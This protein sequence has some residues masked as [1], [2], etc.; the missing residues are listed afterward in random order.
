MQLF[1]VNARSVMSLLSYL[2]VVVSFG[3]LHPSSTNQQPPEDDVMSISITV[4]AHQMN[5]K[6]KL[7]LL[8]RRI[9]KKKLQYHSSKHKLSSFYWLKLHLIIRSPVNFQILMCFD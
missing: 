5:I 7:L 4:A 2:R 8:R 3:Q 9:F 6:A 1:D